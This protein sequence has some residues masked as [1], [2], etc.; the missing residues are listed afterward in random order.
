MLERDRNRDARLD[1]D[2][3]EKRA[4]KVPHTGPPSLSH[5]EPTELG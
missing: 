3:I 5:S 2:E 1:P 4:G